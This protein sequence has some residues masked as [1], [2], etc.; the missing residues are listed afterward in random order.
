MS[1]L[2]P[3]VQLAPEPSTQKRLAAVK[4]AQNPLLEAAQPLLRALA[5]MPAELEPHG[6]TVFHRL[7]EREVTT[8]QSLCNDA[9]I[10]HEH[11][12]AASYSLCTALD[13]AANST[14]WG[15]GTRGEVGVWAGQQ[16]AAH[17][18][19]DTKGGDKFFL[20]IGRLAANP[21]EHTDLLELLYQILGLGFEGRFSTGNQAR[22]QLETIRHR[23][24][25]LLASAR[26]DVPRELSP[27][28]KGEATGKFR[29]LRSVPVWVTA[30]LLS[31]VLLGLFSWYSYQL[32]TTRSG[33]E[34]RIRSIGALQ[35]PPAPPR[36]P[37]RL[38]EL[39][40]AEIARG[41][42]SVDEDNARSAVSFKGDDM[43]V[44]GQARMN[45]KILP[46]IAKV[47]GEINE[48]AGTVQVTG[49]SDNLPIKTREFP[50][51]QVLSEKRAAAAAGV[52]KDNGVA[53]ERL[54]VEGRGDAQPVAS[55][56]T[57]AGRARNRRVDIV[58]MQGSQ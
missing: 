50:D 2:P 24:L 5:D 6:V 30:A 13:E 41:T 7:L 12:V 48:V 43:F 58:V 40:S 23:L 32:Q 34:A 44:P 55:N 21:Q 36:K 18:H 35:P 11:A 8:F 29:L 42:V 10:R 39:L 16:L 17:F 28:W 27:H 47:A 4:A 25:T 19:G 31:L 9:Q 1:D 54:K 26:G 14:V 46:V 45:P 52:L 53:P 20:L 49:H 22:R 33:V 3:I 37:L 57:A 51:N 56:A 38:K 15:G